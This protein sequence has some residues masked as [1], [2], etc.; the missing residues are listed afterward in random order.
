MSD[1]DDYLR[2]CDRL[3]WLIS[4]HRVIEQKPRDYDGLGDFERV[5]LY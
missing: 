3:N 2:N 4:N 5:V 1:I